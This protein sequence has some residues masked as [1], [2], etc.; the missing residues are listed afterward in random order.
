MRAKDVAMRG[1]MSGISF[2]S[3]TAQD[4][5]DLALLAD[6]ATRG[7]ASHLWGMTAAPGQS[8]F[9]IGY[10]T[11]RNTDAHP[12]HFRNW[13][14]AERNGTLAGAL[15]SHV[16]PPPSA[17]PAPDVLKGLNDLKA[18]AAGTWYIS[19]LA[20]LPQ[21]QGQGLGR[22]LLDDAEATARAAGLPHL[23]LMV[24]SFNARAHELYL[25]QGFT[26]QARRPFTPFP[27]SDT[28]GEW[29]LMAKPLT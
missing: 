8:P 15:N 18:M 25:R 17:T 23:T 3:A 14:V 22:A 6:M 19:A 11:I 7:L 27:G 21:H 26:E 29:I 5:A 24:G 16:M 9:Q 2:R 10:T 12:S 13:R 20:L 4:C 1:P 28:P